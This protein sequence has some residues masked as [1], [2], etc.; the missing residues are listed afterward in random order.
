MALHEISSYEPDS[1][2]PPTLEE[3]GGFPLEIYI[4]EG[5]PNHAREAIAFDVTSNPLFSSDPKRAWDRRELPV[6]S[7]SMH[8]PAAVSRQEQAV[9]YLRDL[10]FFGSDDVVKRAIDAFPIDELR[11]GY[12]EYAESERISNDP[13]IR[14]IHRGMG[15][16]GIENS[17]LDGTQPQQLHPRNVALGFTVLLQTEPQMSESLP[18]FLPHNVEQL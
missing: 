1:Y 11:M 9:G 10:T 14:Q 13:L 8:D 16:I 12:R 2:L 3:P 4:G 17:I 18:F 6:V 7:T 5:E 15:R